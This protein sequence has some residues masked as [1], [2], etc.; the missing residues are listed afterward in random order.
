ME[1]NVIKPS[2]AEAVKA[3]FCMI[4]DTADDVL[5]I[6]SM[7]AYLTAGV[8]LADRHFFGYT[9]EQATENMHK[10]IKE[11]INIKLKTGDYGNDL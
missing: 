6:H 3:A 2:K 1:K 7:V 11:A 8:I 4:S 5:D 9:V 10:I